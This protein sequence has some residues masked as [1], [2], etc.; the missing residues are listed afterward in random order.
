M[1]QRF[2]DPSE[3]ATETAWPDSTGRWTTANHSTTVTVDRNGPFKDRIGRIAV[4]STTRYARTFDDV[5]GDANRA[6]FDFA[7]SFRIGA[8]GDE[9]RAFARASGAAGSESAVL[10]GVVS[11]ALTIGEYRNPTYSG[12]L[13]STPYSLTAG[14]W[15][16][17][18]CSGNG[19]TLAAKIWAEGEAEPGSWGITATG[20][21]TGAGWIGLGAFNGSTTGKVDYAFV[22]I[23][24][25]GDAPLSPRTRTQWM[26]WLEQDAAPRCVLAELGMMDA[27]TPVTK[28]LSNV[29]YS[30]T[31]ADDPAS[32]PYTE[33]IVGVPSYR[34]QATNLF[35]GQS[36]LAIGELLL[37]NADGS[38]DSW[39]LANVDGR[40]ARILL[41]GPTWPR[42]DFRTFALGTIRAIHTD[43][44]GRLAVQLRDRQMLANK[45]VQ[46]ETISGGDTEGRLVPLTVGAAF[47]LDPVPTND[48]AIEYQVHDGAVSSIGDAWDN[49]VRLRTIVTV[50]SID[51]GTDT[52]TTS[53]N[54]GA[55]TGWE[56]IFSGSAAPG[57]ITFGT[58]YYVRAGYTG[59]TLTVA[60]TP[61]GGP[62]NITSSGTSVT[63][64]LRGRQ[65]Y[66]STGKVVMATLPA[67]E[68]RIDQ[69][70]GL[71]DVASGMAKC[72]D[73]LLKQRLSLT[74]YIDDA[75]ITAHDAAHGSACG[76][77][78]TERA[79]AL[80]VFDAL[81]ANY[82]TMYGFDRNG[83]FYCV[84]LTET[85]SSARLTIT[86]DMI[87]GGMNLDEVLMPVK[88]YRLLAAPNANPSSQF[89]TSVAG[90]VRAKYA[91]THQLAYAD[92]NSDGT[93]SPAN[94]ALAYESRDYPQTYYTTVAGD[95][96]Y[97]GRKAAVWS[98]DMTLSGIDLRL[99]DIVSIVYPRYGFESGRGAQVIATADNLDRQMVRVTVIVPNY[100]QAAAP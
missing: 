65:A 63:I 42:Y 92:T 86:A 78:L 64:T 56:A 83:L 71:S 48:S 81:F 96:G 4:T 23:G 91:G 82:P 46:T 49:A 80:D 45:P 1:T 79:N 19:T 32:Q 100:S 12:A 50:S 24:T 11:G 51:T 99:G 31:A 29:P 18:R 69:V 61:G 5:D 52:I 43:G 90:A 37:D 3:W 70:Y 9:P 72:V 67:G 33:A 89:A 40:D 39:L 68:L 34:A 77:Y 60:D 36:T 13:N 59:N 21:M 55:V 28:Y 93:D 94:H 53:T 15:Y 95:Y 14:T 30:S 75:S 38:R 6:T 54:H 20:T 16:R 57:G 84:A 44:L 98:F 22:S 26:A 88:S 76:V 97:F 66:P 87:R 74:G 73:Y 2:F 8:S 85:V 25:N 58:A 7:F 10:F 35:A 41:G 27:A 62:V 17:M 47:W